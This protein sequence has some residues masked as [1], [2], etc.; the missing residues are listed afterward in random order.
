M[1]MTT[2]DQSLDIDSDDRKILSLVQK[3]SG[4]TQ[5][6]IAAAINKIQ[7]AVGARLLRLER[8]RL[9]SSQY[10]INLSATRIPMA[11]VR[12]YA[13][14]SKAVLKSI[15]CCPNVLNAFTTLGRTNV[16]VILAG[17]SIEKLEDIAEQHFRS[18]PDIKHVEMAVVMEPVT[19]TILPV[20]LNIETHDAMKCGGACHAKAATRAGKD[21][22]YGPVPRGKLDSL[23]KGIDA[24]DRQIIMAMEQDPEVTQEDL[25]EITGLSQPAV[26]S[27]IAKLQKAGVLAIRKG[28]NF[29]A[30]SGLGF[31]QVAISTAD[32][33]GMVKKLRACPIVSLGFRIV[34]DASIVAYIGGNSLDEVEEIVDTCIRADERVKSVETVP[35]ISYLKDL[36]LPF[37]FECD[38]TPGIGCAGCA[39]CNNK[40][41]K[42]LAAF[43]PRTLP[44]NAAR[45]I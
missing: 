12:M 13:K 14:H 23:I 11:L 45:A 16:T 42:E 17:S 15:E 38:F 26:G 41:S 29:K 5:A 30:V 10:G 2:L 35:V 1:V 8:K 4:I 40:V 31:V 7:P 43:V 39:A 28:V 3:N 37:N 19:D 25:G 44:P 22:R 34:S 33:A 6:E 9:L 32:V 21:A 24:K 27:R 18:N 36:V 20:D